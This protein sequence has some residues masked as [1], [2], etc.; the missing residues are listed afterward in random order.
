VS[1]PIEPINQ[2][3]SR[4]AMALGILRHSHYRW[5]WAGVGFVIVVRFS[6]YAWR[7]LLPSDF[8]LLYWSA[9]HL[10]QGENPYP[11]STQWYHFWPLYYPLPAVFLAVPFTILPVELA[12]PI[13]DSILGCTFAYALWRRRGPYA[14]LALLSGAY[15][16]AMRQ[17]QITPLIVAASLLPALGGLL[18]LKPNMGLAL[19]LS[20]PTSPAV[21]GGIVLLAVSLVVLP[22]WPRDWWTA[23]QGNSDHLRP[24]IFRPFGFLLLLAA[25]RWRTPEGRLLAAL[26][27]IPQNT[28]PHELVT[29]ALIPANVVQ[30]G[31]YV[32]GTWV[33]LAVTATVQ[34]GR[35][36]L[37][38]VVTRVWP[39]LLTTVYLPMLWLVLTRP[40]PSSSLP[41]ESADQLLPV[42]NAAD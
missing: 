23:L 16:F 33:T 41:K 17:G 9:V 8:D 27:L 7:P 20:R 29:L 21:I 35:P 1:T 10:L 32:A 4:P 42:T 36:D 26:A 22:S 38:E 31:I 3:V 13:F 5:L 18:V 24:P 19:W 12:R 2:S 14:L 37:T 40:T 15:L 39:V 28:L 34:S 11:I 30:M 6:L 25:L